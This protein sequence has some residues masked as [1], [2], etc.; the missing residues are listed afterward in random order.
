MKFTI[1]PLTHE[2]YDNHL[3]GWWKD[4][5]WLPPARD[6]LPQDG[7]GGLMV[8]DN[9][10]PVCA[11]FIYNTNSKV[12]WVDWIISDKSYRKNPERQEALELLINTLSDICSQSGNKYAYALLRHKG[13]TKT[14]Q[15]LGFKAG[16]QYTQEMIKVFK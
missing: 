14:Y 2:D 12:G 3:V 7:T 5:K 4:W 16:D 9:E 10:T 1:K 11:G 8:Y 13:L 6:F 15:G